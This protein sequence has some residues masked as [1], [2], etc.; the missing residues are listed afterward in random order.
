MRALK[1]YHG[2]LLALERRA[3]TDLAAGL[4]LSWINAVR[5][6]AIAGGLI[7]IGG[8]LVAVLARAGFVVS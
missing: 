7:T 5:E 3:P 4:V 8:G 6:V 2:G 1:A